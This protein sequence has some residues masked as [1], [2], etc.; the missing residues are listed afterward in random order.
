MHKLNQMKLQ[1]GLGTLYV[2]HQETGQAYCTASRACNG[3]QTL[4]Q[5][6]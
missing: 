4:E 5:S 2:L 3:W 1:P 6:H